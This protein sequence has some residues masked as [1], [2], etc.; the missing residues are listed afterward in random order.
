MW[1][2]ANI[3]IQPSCPLAKRHVAAPRP[4]SRPMNPTAELYEVRLACSRGP[5]LTNLTASRSA[6]VWPAIRPGP[7]H[8]TA[9]LLLPLSQP[10]P[11]WSR[12]FQ[13]AP[14]KAKYLRK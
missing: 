14:S 10:H 13:G 2:T 4:M 12:C 5:R 9:R 7:H 11:C 1:L 8:D 6:L 3:S